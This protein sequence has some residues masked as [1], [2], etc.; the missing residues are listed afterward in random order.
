M[1]ITNFT[2]GPDNLF[3]LW[4]G[5]KNRQA[6][7]DLRSVPAPYLNLARVAKRVQVNTETYDKLRSAIPTTNVQHSH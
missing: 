5:K 4:D 7:P 3:V 1:L 6:W 2:T